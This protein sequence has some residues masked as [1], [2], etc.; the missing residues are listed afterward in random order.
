M[1]ILF[2]VG[3]LVVIAMMRRPPDRTALHGRS[4]QH[5]KHELGHA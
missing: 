4:A 1:R 5:A 3:I 2:L